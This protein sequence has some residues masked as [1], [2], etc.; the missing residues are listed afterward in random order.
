MRTIAKVLPFPE[1]PIARMRNPDAFGRVRGDGRA[2]F[3]ARLRELADQ[4]ESGELDGARAQ[5]R[6]DDG[7]ETEMVTVVRTAGSDGMVQMTT[8]TIEKE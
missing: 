8:T 3:V 4:I 6:D 1:S 5:W 2:L 7:A